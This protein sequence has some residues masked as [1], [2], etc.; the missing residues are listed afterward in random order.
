[1]VNKDQDRF[2]EGLTVPRMCWAPWE[3]LMGRPGVPGA[4]GEEEGGGE[5]AF[6]HPE[7]NGG[8]AG[9]GPVSHGRGRG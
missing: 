9:G 8:R 2:L 4:G 3:G 7:V 6:S 5:G 1:M